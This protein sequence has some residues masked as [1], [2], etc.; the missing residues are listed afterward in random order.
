MTRN[1]VKRRLR[2][3][4]RHERAVLDGCWD[5]VVIARSSAARA[6]AESLRGQLAK[7]VN[8]VGEGR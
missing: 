4:I 5:V 3:A 2:E 1:L 8:V 7:A 6:S